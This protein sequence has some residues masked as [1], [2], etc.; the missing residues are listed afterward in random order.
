M[1]AARIRAPSHSKRNLLPLSSLGHRTNQ[2]ARHLS[3]LSSTSC[4]GRASWDT[5]PGCSGLL[6]TQA[7]H[8]S[9]DG[10]CTTSQSNLLHRGQKHFLSGE[11][12]PQ[13]LW[14]VYDYSACSLHWNPHSPLWYFFWCHC[15]FDMRCEQQASGST[16]DAVFMSWKKYTCDCLFYHKC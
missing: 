9:R 16:T 8:T 7:L 2:A 14:E 5:R 4:S 13:C 3:V 1:T 6:S 11:K 10:A 15:V 12:V